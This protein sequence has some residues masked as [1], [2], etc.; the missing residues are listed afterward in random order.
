MEGDGVVTLHARVAVERRGGL[1]GNERVEEETAEAAGRKRQ[2]QKYGQLLLPGKE[3]A[4]AQSSG[5]NQIQ[6]IGQQWAVGSRHRENVERVG[7]WQT[8]T[9]GGQ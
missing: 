7:R 4:R 1:K 3:T 8:A 5:S 6:S 2:A 9:A